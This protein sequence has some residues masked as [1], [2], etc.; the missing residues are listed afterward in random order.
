MQSNGSRPDG[1]PTLPFVQQTSP[2]Q[3]L[4]RS[5]RGDASSYILITGGA[6][7]IGTNLAERLLSQG[8]RVLIFDNLSRAGVKTNLAWLRTRYPKRLD[9]Q[10]GDLCDEGQIQEAVRG[11]SAVFHFAAQVAVTTSV[12]DPQH[13]FA[14]NAQ[15]T[16]HLLEAVR[17]LAPT[18]PVF[19]TSTNKVYGD[20][21]DISL[22]QENARYE[23]Q[24]RA[25]RQFGVGEDRSLSFH[26]PYGCSK[27]VA[28]Q[29]IL[30]YCRTFDLRGA[31]FRMS[32]IYGP[33]QFG[34]EDQGWVAHFIL[35]A[36]QGQPITLYGDGKQVRDIL[37]VDD[38]VDAFLWVHD[39][40]DQVSGEAFNIGGGPANSIS[41]LE[42]IDLI[43][44]LQSD[45]V[46]LRFGDWRAGD[47]RYYVSDIRKFAAAAGWQPQ[48]DVAT[49]VHRLYGWLRQ[50]RLPNTLPQPGRAKA[51]TLAPKP[52]DSSASS[53]K[54]EAESEHKHHV[55]PVER[56]PVAATRS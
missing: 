36:L 28:D 56:Y 38:L 45:A 53:R 50:Y 49:G 32:C 30:D 41:L 11:A 6:G 14:V 21:A 33:H 48:V 26:G 43:E 37:S 8:Q 1:S 55:E 7:F 42:L 40:I 4:W 5:P 18:A 24:D 15:G 10:L 44:E 9:V 52:T 31:V 39:H 25:I 22:V 35:R 2:N 27:G 17:H 47:Q 20:L 12:A 23:P 51:A 13:D 16:L 29:Y 19:F 3:R 46:Q 34:N 54:R